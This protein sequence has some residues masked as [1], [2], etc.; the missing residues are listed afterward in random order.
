M[1]EN[2]LSAKIRSD[3]ATVDNCNTNLRSTPI[4]PSIPDFQTLLFFCDRKYSLSIA[5]FALWALAL[6]ID[7][8]FVLGP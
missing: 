5:L 8:A 3:R 7:P 4:S 1:I 6:F 2:A